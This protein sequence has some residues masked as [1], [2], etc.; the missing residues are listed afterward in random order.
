MSTVFLDKPAIDYPDSDG[1]PM[2][3]NTRQYECMVTI[4]GGLDVVFADKPDVFVA[5]DL[6]WYPVENHPEIR[7]APDVYVAFGRPKGHRGSYKQWM[8]DGV[9][10]QVVFEVL[11]PRNTAAEMAN[12]RA[13]YERYGVDEYYVHDPDRGTLVGYRREGN[14]LT[15][16]PVMR[17][18][19]SPRLQVR[20]E[21]VDGELHLYA[22]DGR[23]FQSFVEMAQDRDRALER[24]DF[25]QQ[26]ADQLTE[27]LR[28]HG[29]E[30]PA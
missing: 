14:R 20:F 24:A 22:P 2:A 3:D 23:R 11:S 28:Q 1:Q 29:I 30:P 6:L 8:E 5:G 16:I 25:G 9:A 17:G 12:K 15:E 19:I 10:P 13:F 21:L 7:M 27:L 18:H 26:R 4:K